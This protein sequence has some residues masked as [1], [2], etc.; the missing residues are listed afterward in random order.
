MNRE[1]LRLAL[2]S[3]ISNITVPLLGLID[4][5]I[6]GH[7]D[8]TAYIGAIAVGGL[9]FNMLYWNFGFLRMGTS[10][11]T[12]QAYGRG[13]AK[14]QM[15]ILMQAMVVGLS[16]AL[17]LLLFTS[18]IESL[19]FLFID[20]SP[21]VAELA[22]DYYRIVIF[23]APAILG[24][25]AFNG[26]FIGMQNTRYP[27]FIAIIMNVVN[28]G[29]SLVLVYI[30]DLKIEG[31]ALGTLI[32][33]YAGLF[34]ALG[35]W[36]KRY[37]G[38]GRGCRISDALNG[39]E[40]K[41]FFTL[42]SAIFFRTLCL[43]AVTTLFTWVGG[44]QGDTILAVNTLL[45]QLFTIFSYILDGFAY[46][47]ESLVGRFTGAATYA[48][49]RKAIQYLFR[50]SAMVMVLFTVAYW[51]GGS[52]F[53]SLLTDNDEV[54]NLSE[55]YFYW[56]LAVPLCGFSAFLWDGILI[57]A[58]ATKEM[59]WAMLIAA[60]LFFATLFGVP[61]IV[62]G[63]ASPMWSEPYNNHRLWLAFL[64]Y[65]TTRGVVQHLLWRRE[66][67]RPDSTT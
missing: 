62:S 56:V 33:Q 25:Y 41:R 63:E 35:L 2:P 64:I 13:D 45:M 36:L 11:L 34:M 30:F 42:N 32:A 14:G 38:I 52:D 65:L 58:T 54:L 46:A 21:Q 55:H 5:A 49:R 17:L 50:W 23:G 24:M 15:N 1:I 48:L 3:I 26:W 22:S 8:S 4:V 18:P 59:F 28:I 57:G 20:T 53:L 6:T 60:I 29:A 12:A 61:F 27:M 10:G 19:I 37:R 43:I 9:I 40:L 66:L 51:L 7:F 67:N 16:A 44:K 39:F 31:V 47:A